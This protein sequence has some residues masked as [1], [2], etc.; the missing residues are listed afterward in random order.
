MN[1]MIKF[2]LIPI[3]FMTVL[4]LVNL[5]NSVLSYSEDLS[6]QTTIKANNINFD[7]PSTLIFELGSSPFNLTYAD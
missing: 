6:N 4:I 1:M 2:I 5:N 3:S 7:I